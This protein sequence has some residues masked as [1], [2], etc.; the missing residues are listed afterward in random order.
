MRWSLGVGLWLLVLLAQQA[1][2]QHALS[3][4]AWAEPLVAQH[5]PGHVPARDD[6]GHDNACHECLAFHAGVHAMP[7]GVAVLLPV[8]VNGAASPA[9][10]PVEHLLAGALAYQSRAPPVSV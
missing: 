10:L 9:V 1:G 4:V 8:N 7:A 6:L 2:W 5:D 3:H